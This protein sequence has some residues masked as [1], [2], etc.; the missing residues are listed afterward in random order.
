MEILQTKQKMV[1]DLLTDSAVFFAFSN[2]QFTTNKTPLKEGEKYVAIGHGGYIPK[3]NLDTFLDGMENINKWYKNQVKKN[4]EER[5]NLIIYQLGNYECFY[6]GDI[7][8]AL[9]A[10]G[11]TFT[12]KEV[13]KVYNELITKNTY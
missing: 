7:S 11:D 10:L 4:K 2:E 8:D 1:D 13:I 12:R 3:N 5:R 9:E 6:T